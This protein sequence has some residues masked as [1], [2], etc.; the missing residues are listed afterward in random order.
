MSDYLIQRGLFWHFFRRVPAEYADLDRRNIVAQS[1]KVRVADDPNRQR[2]RRTADKI[3]TGLESYW[4][5]LAQG[6][7]A[8]AKQRYR[9]AMQ[10]ARRLGFDYIPIT[11]QSHM[12]LV[13][14]IEAL[15]A[16]GLLEKEPAAQAAL[17]RIEPPRIMV[18]DVLDQYA[19]HVRANLQNKSEAQTRHW[20][21][22]RK[23]V[24]TDFLTACGDKPLAQLTRTDANTFRSWW[25]D[26]IENRG[27]SRDSANN[28]FGLLRVMCETVARE[29]D[30]DLGSMFDKIRFK[31]VGNQ[32]AAFDL[33][34]IKGRLLAPG[35]LDDLGADARHAFYLMLET[36]MRPSEITGLDR[37]TINLDAEV[38]HVVVAESDGNGSARRELKN[39]NSRREIPLVGVALKAMKLHPNG[40]ERYHLRP[41]TLSKAVQRYLQEHKLLPTPEHSFYSLR[42]SFKDRLRAVEAPGELLDMLMGHSNNKPKYG[43]GYPLEVKRKWLQ[44]ISLPVPSKV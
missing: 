12:E 2:A 28:Q 3:N 40:F 35:A 30:I 21:N 27:Y 26:R 19:G 20:T 33:E 44:R 39:K 15:E 17:G 38:P 23:G 36:G 43:K 10:R 9:E 41:N 42:H 8:G 13:A 37:S 31:A 25:S 18:S 32:R 24:M 29:H 34:F 16:R 5:D 11:E 14:R 1:T 7:A 4:R 6:K 22:L